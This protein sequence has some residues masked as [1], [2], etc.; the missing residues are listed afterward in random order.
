MRKL[1]PLVILGALLVIA[2]G[3]YYYRQHA[4]SGV[5]AATNTA[6]VSTVEVA[7]VVEQAMPRQI[8]AYGSLVANNDVMLSTQRA[9]QIA[10]IQFQQ[11][12]RADKGQLLVKLDDSS[13][14]A[15]VE[16]AQLELVAAKAT[17][18]RTQTLVERS[19]ASQSDLEAANAD[20][21]QKQAALAQAQAEL[22]KCHIEAP[23]AGSLGKRLV[24]VGDYVGV[25]APL[26]QLVELQNIKAEY[27]VP[28][29]FLPWLKLGQIVTLTSSTYPDK[30]FTAKVTFI[31]PTID[32]E[33]RSVAIQAEVPN[34]DELLKPGLF[35]KVDQTLGTNQHALVVPEE[36]LVPSIDGQ[37]VYKIVDQHVTQTPVAVG[38]RFQGL[39][40]ITDGLQAGDQIVTAGQQKLKDGSAV[41][42]VNS[43]NA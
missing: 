9:G 5:A 27:Q 16:S 1:F 11:G 43:S 37:Y 28:E 4:H 3:V 35:I 13:E 14:Q 42:V 6:P 36:S 17:F 19:V 30:T 7:T 15:A 32:P 20:M 40:E 25:G 31:A 39:A 2:G 21:A 18:E 10:E 34:H 12:A 24:S 41:Q 26:V 8:D 23:F 22:A 29:R 33:T 38:S